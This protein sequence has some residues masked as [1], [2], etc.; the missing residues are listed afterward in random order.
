[1]KPTCKETARIISSDED[2]P[3]IQKSLLRVHLVLCKY[4]DHYAKQITLVREGFRNHISRK[5]H[6]DSKKLKD[7]ENRIIQKIKHNN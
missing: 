2:L 1:M 3:W 6:I 7:L 4:C 5:I